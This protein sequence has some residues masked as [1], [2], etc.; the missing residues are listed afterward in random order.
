MKVSTCAA[1]C[2]VTM[3][4]VAGAG[5]QIRSPA[6]EGPISSPGAAFVAYLSGIVS[7]SYTAVQYALLSSLTFLIGSLGRGIA[8]EAF[9]QFGYATVFRWTAAAGLAAVFFVLLEWVRVGRAQRLSPE[10]RD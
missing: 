4:L 2:V 8:G 9:D 6:I 3:V 7:K 1:G 10:T 5:A